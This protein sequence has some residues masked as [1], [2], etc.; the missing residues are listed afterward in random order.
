MASCLSAVLIRTPVAAS[1]CS[2]LRPHLYIDRRAAECYTYTLFFLMD[3]RF[4]G[5]APYSE[6]SLCA[7]A[8]QKRAVCRKCGCSDPSTLVVECQRLSACGDAPELQHPIIASRYKRF[9][10]RGEGDRL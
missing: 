9:T 5:R 7:H 3:F 8:H 2:L 4:G 10:V 6:R 1:Y